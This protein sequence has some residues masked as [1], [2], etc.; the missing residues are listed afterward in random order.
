L[1]RPLNLREHEDD[2]LET[3]QLYL[4]LQNRERKNWHDPQNIFQPYPNLRRVTTTPEIHRKNSNKTTTLA[5]EGVGD[6][7]ACESQLVPHECNGLNFKTL[8]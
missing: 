3:L 7:R 6:A 5:K 1:R 2:H 8:I 4:N